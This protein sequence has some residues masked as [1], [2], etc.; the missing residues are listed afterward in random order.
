MRLP[1]H[2]VESE[3]FK[4]QRWLSQKHP[5]YEGRFE[6]DNKAVFKPS[7]HGPRDCI[8]KNLAYAELRLIT[9]R[10]LYRFDFDL[11][12]DHTTWFKL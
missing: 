5:L 1:Q 8:G 2:R 4:P 3:E 6:Q 12:G 7:S 9:C 10:L 11:V